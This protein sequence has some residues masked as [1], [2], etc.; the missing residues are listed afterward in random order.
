MEDRY[1][2]VS[3]VNWPA[4]SVDDPIATKCYPKTYEDAMQIARPWAEQGYDVV[5]TTREYED[6][7]V[8]IEI[9]LDTCQY[10]ENLNTEQSGAV[11]K[12]IYAYFFD[13]MEPD[14]KDDMVRDAT[15]KIIDRVKEYAENEQ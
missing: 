7:D 14:Y 9:P 1:Y 6:E 5:I 12:N 8:H 3:I 4:E 10:I 2:I 15:I 11:F 13:G